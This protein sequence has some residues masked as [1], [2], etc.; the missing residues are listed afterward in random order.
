MAYRFSRY[1]NRTTFKNTD[2]S[3]IKQFS[4]R[5]VDSI[6]QHTTANFIWDASLDFEEEYW[7]VGSRFYK[8]ADK[9]YGDAS[10]WWIIPWFNQRP[11]ESDFESGDLVMIPVPLEQVLSAFDRE[12]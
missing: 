1:Q 4:S 8:L 3:Y 5:K 6:D 11:L 7:G 9:Y 2:P 10:L 12:A